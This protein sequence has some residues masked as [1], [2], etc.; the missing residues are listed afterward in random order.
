M[1]DRQLWQ[2]ARNQIVPL[3]RAVLFGAL[4][5]VAIVVQAWLLSSIIA[6][7]FLE[8]GTLADQYRNL[9]W[10]GGVI[11]LRAVFVYLREVSAGAVSIRVRSGLM[12]QLFSNILTTSPV[13]LS[14]E[15]TGEI[16]NTLLQGVDR[17]D[18]YFRVYLPQLGMA[19]IIPVI[20]LLVVFPLDWLTG[21]IFLFTAPLIP[22]FMVLIGKEAESRTDR[23]WKLLGRLSGHFLDVLQGLRT[24]KAFGLSKRQAKVI[25]SVSEEYAAITLGVLRIA[26]LSALT[27]ELLATISTAVVA[28]QIG[29]RLMYGQIDFVSSLFILIL[30]PEFYFPLR[31]LGAAFH[32]GMEGNAA[33]ESIFGLLEDPVP[34]VE[35]T[36]AD[37]SPLS[38]QDIKFEHVKYSY[39][40]GDRPSLEGVSFNLPAG[41]QT[42]LVGTSG[43]GKSTIFSLLLGFIRPDEGVIRVGEA[44]LDEI[45]AEDWLGKI[46]WVPQ[47]PYLF[48]DTIL[49]NI[50]I[51]KPDASEEE[52]LKAA[53]RARV[54]E[55]VSQLPVG[56]ETV[57][58]ERGIQLSGGQAQRLAIARAFLRDADLILLDEPASSLDLANEGAIREALAELTVGR[59]VLT[60]SH[61]LG[62]IQTADQIIVIEKGAVCQV[63]THSELAGVQGHYQKLISLAG[64]RS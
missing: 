5:G 41:K 37:F 45:D 48:F 18:A 50:R 12:E 47:F 27:L 52:I 4:L 16:T 20:V 36:R 30:A 21:L 60:I 42:A 25:K 24:L 1:F 54:D 31:Q 11:L 35:A 15:R 44:R 49:A 51:A 61:K 33:A 29:L 46:S 3:G 53:K 6:G 23:Q 7:V 43:A 55:F 22:L 28:V 64:R 62:S 9:I 58:G 13:K 14:G 17:L 8:G 32:S 63:G 39:Q 56:Y 2:Q 57:I 40:G 59:T 19:V 10:L 26:F 34:K 38:R